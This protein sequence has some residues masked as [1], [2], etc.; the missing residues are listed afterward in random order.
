MYWFQFI[1]ISFLSDSSGSDKFCKFK[2]M[3]LVKQIDFQEGF[4]F[5]L[6]A[7]VGGEGRV[8]GEREGE[9]RCE[10]KRNYKKDVEKHFSYILLIIYERYNEENRTI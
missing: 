7:C 6:F 4:S 1:V 3:I 2:W 5:T 8:G 9:R 10:K